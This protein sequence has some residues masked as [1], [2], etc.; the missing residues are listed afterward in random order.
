MFYN[1]LIELWSYLLQ[2]AR[3]CT[4]F[5]NVSLRV[6]QIILPCGSCPLYYT[7]TTHSSLQVSRFN[8]FPFRNGLK[9]SLCICVSENNLHYMNGFKFYSTFATLK[10]LSVVLSHSPKIIYFIFY[11][12]LLRYFIHNELH[13]MQFFVNNR[14]FRNVPHIFILV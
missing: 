1:F 12:N 14:I 7:Q 6:L 3:Y 11:S 4:S 2:F 13:C 5:W 9:E 10:S 8:S